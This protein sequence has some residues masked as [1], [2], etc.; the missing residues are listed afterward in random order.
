MIELLMHVATLTIIDDLF[1]YI[2]INWAKMILASDSP[3]NK[4]KNK[5]NLSSMERL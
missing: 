1:I 4:I 3:N 2:Y 5:K